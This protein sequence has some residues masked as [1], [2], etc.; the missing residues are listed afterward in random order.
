[1]RLERHERGAGERRRAVRRG[2]DRRRLQHRR[3]TSS[4]SKRRP[5]NERARV[6]R[7]R[8]V[9]VGGRNGS[10]EITSQ[11]RLVTAPLVQPMLAHGQPGVAASSGARWWS[12]GTARRPAR[13]PAAEERVV[14]V[15]L[16]ERPA[17]R[18]EQHDR[19]RSCSAEGGD[20]P[21]ELRE[22]GHLAAD[23]R[24]SGRATLPMA[25]D[26]GFKCDA[27]LPRREHITEIDQHPRHARHRDAFDASD[28]VEGI[29]PPI[30]VEDDPLDG[31]WRPGTS[32]WRS[33]AGNRDVRKTAAQ[34]RWART[35]PGPAA[36]TAAIACASGESSPGPNE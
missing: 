34:D 13:S 27:W 36:S 16:H 5:G 14:G 23:P 3:A 11:R 6:D 22:A 21:R 26:D 2:R 18:V 35:A 12:T 20:P 30:A 32:T 33:G 31:R 29:E 15:A 8:V 17:E 10:G 24:L 7:Q 28:H 25:A 9:A 1:M 19:E 4:R